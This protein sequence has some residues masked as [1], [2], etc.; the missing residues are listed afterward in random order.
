MLNVEL[1]QRL[2][3]EYHI[4]ATRMQAESQP[5]KKMFYFSIFFGEAQRILNLQWDRD[6]ALIFLVTQQAHTQINPTIQTPVYNLLPIQAKT[7]FD[8]L[9]KISLDLASYMEK[10]GEM[11]RTELCEILGRVAEVTYAVNGNG[12]YLYEK[13]EIKF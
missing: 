4:A 8:Q 1:K 5:A 10:P 7:V 9:T 2:A 6:L 3:S 13:G 12:S 11:D